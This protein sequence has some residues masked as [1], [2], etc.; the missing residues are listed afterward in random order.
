M[1]LAV[2]L[3]DIVGDFLTNFILFHNKEY[4]S[5]L[6]REDFHNYLYNE[7]LKLSIEE[8]KVR[9]HKFYDSNLCKE[10]LPMPGSLTALPLLKKKGVKLFLITGRH[11][12]IV[13]KTKEWVEE[14]F[15]NIFSD[16]YHTS[17]H[18]TNGLKVK[19]SK[20]CLDLGAKTIIEDDWM[21]ITD[22]ASKGIKVMVYNHPW[23][24]RVLPFGAKRFLGWKGIFQELNSGI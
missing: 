2:D 4:G 23:N 20:V 17:A 14:N 19:K 5:T 24:Q 21:H 7:I 15:P 16:I 6:K 18:E 12:S 11:N 13:D 1:K 3:D 22:C 9:M 10:I 8:T